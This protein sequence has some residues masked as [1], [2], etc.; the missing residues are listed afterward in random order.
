MITTSMTPVSV[1]TLSAQSK[2][3]LPDCTH[4]IT[5]VTLASAVPPMK[6]RKIGQLSAQETNSAPVVS[7]LATVLPS[8]RLPSPET[9]AAS[10]G[11]KTMKRIGFMTLPRK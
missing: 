8:I 6:A 4:C 1:S 9:I 3:R 5:G 11:R 2:L 7:D 10:S